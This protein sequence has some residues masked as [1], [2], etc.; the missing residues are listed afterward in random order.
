MA[1]QIL[2]GK[3]FIARFKSRFAIPCF[4]GDKAGFNRSRRRSFEGKLLKQ[5]R[6]YPLRGIWQN[7]KG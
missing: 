7:E 1:G 4:H 5:A 6:Q 3:K 2:A